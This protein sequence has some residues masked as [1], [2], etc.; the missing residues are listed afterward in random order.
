MGL[1]SNFP[2][3][4]VGG[5]E[6][7]PPFLIDRMDL[8]AILGRKFKEFLP[9]VGAKRKVF[10]KYLLSQMRLV[11]TNKRRFSPFYFEPIGY[12]IPCFHML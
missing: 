10:V 1:N 8:C 3:L 7:L 9:V 2:I 11:L 4:T 12:C 6:Y 5:R